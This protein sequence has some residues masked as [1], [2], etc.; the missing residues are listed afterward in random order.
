MKI[1]PLLKNISSYLLFTSFLF[2]I[3]SCLNQSNNSVRTSQYSHTPK[4]TIKNKVI[5]DTNLQR[6]DFSKIPADRKYNDIARYIAG[7][8]AWPRKPLC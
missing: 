3:N 2:L 7:M 6:E 5:S 1:P 8:K 4:D